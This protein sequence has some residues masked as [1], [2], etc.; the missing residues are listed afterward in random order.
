MPPWAD[1]MYFKVKTEEHKQNGIAAGEQ[2]INDRTMDAMAWLWME[3]QED[4]ERVENE[5]HIAEFINELIRYEVYLYT[6][7]VLGKLYQNLAEASKNEQGSGSGEAAATT[8][9]KAADQ[10]NPFVTA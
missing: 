4:R 10:F 7:D 1:D 9:R 5:W 8:I 6:L 2:V 3:Y